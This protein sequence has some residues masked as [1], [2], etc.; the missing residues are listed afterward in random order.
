MHV[1]MSFLSEWHVAPI[2][3]YMVTFLT[4]QQRLSLFV[5]LGVADRA[6]PTYIY[7]VY[8]P[9]HSFDKRT[10]NHHLRPQRMKLHHHVLRHRTAY[11]RPLIIY[12]TS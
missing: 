6:A 9:Q 3:I 11:G 5:M 2:Y 8:I 12:Y 7:M 4:Y 10:N 1:Y